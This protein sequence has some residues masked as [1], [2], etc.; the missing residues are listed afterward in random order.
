MYIYVHVGST[1]ESSIFSQNFRNRESLSG[2]CD[3]CFDN[4]GQR[5][6]SKITRD[7]EG[8]SEI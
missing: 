6:V 1:L 3:V 2:D 7:R 5:N 4:L 8:E